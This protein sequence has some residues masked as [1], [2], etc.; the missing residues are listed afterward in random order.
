MTPELVEQAFKD[1]G[2]TKYQEIVAELKLAISRVELRI[3]QAYETLP[4]AQAH[5]ATKQDRLLLKAQVSYLDHLE[6]RR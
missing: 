6:G 5:E 4:V 1:G 2:M 3:E